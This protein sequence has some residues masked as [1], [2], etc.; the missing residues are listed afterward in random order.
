MAKRRSRVRK[1]VRKPRAGGKGTRAQ[2]SRAAAKRREK[3]LAIVDSE[4][5][6]SLELRARLGL[7][8]KYFVGL[9]P[10]SPRNLA[11]LESGK[12]PTRPLLRHLRSLD[13]LVA[14]LAEVMPDESIGRWLQQSN[15]TFGGQKPIDVIDRGEVDRIWKMIFDLRGR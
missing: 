12:P 8:R 5:G 10:M 6:R 15:K 3:S 7:S 1:A 9:V 14:A 13:R 2:R 11:Y 4:F